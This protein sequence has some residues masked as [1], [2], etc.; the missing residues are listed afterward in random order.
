MGN[1]V[2]FYSV[3]LFQLI[4][5]MIQCYHFPKFIENSVLVNF[6]CFSTFF[7]LSPREKNLEKEST[8]LNTGVGTLRRGP[9]VC[10]DNFP[11][12]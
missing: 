1:L 8:P 12:K 11:P 10:S 6:E 5:S 3:S 7:L 4:Y 9:Y 2:F